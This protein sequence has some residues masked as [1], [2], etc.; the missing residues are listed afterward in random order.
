[1]ICKLRVM[2]YGNM[3]SGAQINVILITDVVKDA[4]LENLYTL[5][6]LSTLK[7]SVIPSL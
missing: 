5:W 1:M 4:P 2:S 7:Q 3:I 6:I